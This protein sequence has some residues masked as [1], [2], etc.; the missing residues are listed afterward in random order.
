MMK[1]HNLNTIRTSH[2]P[3]DPRM[4]ALY[5]YYG[6]YVMD[7]ADLENHGNNSISGMP[8]WIPAFKDRIERVIQRDKNHPSV[9]F[10]SLGNEGGN[11]DNF[12]EMYKV[13]KLLDPSRPVHY[14]GK[15]EVADIDS[16]MY[17]DLARMA[18]FDQRDTDKP[19]FLCEYVHSMGN[20]PGNIAEY[21][22]Y[23]ENKSQRMIGGCV[24]DWVD[25]GLNMYGKP[26]NQ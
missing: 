4:Y 21:W 20:A 24:W 7:E 18:A 25:Q 13:A 8:S 26:D 15:N 11:G 6:L 23:I 12:D 5:D 10:W 9:I 1:Q 22:D 17:P 2:Y 16:H 19:Y 14:E 3:N